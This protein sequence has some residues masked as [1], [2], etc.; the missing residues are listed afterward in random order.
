M[1][2]KGNAHKKTLGEINA[3]KKKLAAERDNI[4][5]LIDELQSYEEVADR[6]VDELQHAADTLS[7]YL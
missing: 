3:I 2:V 1:A 4:R 5:D 6:A 7:E